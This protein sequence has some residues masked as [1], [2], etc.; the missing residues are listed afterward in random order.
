M[1]VAKG[2]IQRAKKEDNVTAVKK[3][4]PTETF[5]REIFVR[6]LGSAIYAISK[7]GTVNIMGSRRN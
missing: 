5:V 4:I 2:R 7:M 1:D 3:K 6:Q